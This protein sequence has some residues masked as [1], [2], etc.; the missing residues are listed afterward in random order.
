MSA[1]SQLP[2]SE[3]AFLAVALVGGGLVVGFLAG[4]LGIGGGGIMVPIL[5][6]LFGA[7]GVPE[8]IRMHLSVATSLAVIIPT[9]IR[10][11]RAH[12]KKGAVD[13]Q[14]IRDLGLPVFLGVLLGIVVAGYAGGWLL[15]VFFAVWSL[16]IAAHLYAGGRF[17]L[18]TE[19]PGPAIGRPVGFV[20]GLN[21]T[22]IGI[23]GGAQI[24]A[25]MTLFGR[26]IHQAVATASGFGPIIAIPAVLGYVWSGWHA[27]GQPMGSLGYVNVLGAALIT[28]LSVLAAPYGAR[29]AHGM[30]RRTLEIC[31][32]TFLTITSLRFIW[33][34]I[35]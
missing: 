21:S 14:V 33:T 26:T 29:T 13:H 20:V 25:Y 8:A 34:M 5:Y 6:E 3:I 19:L 23:G 17:K 10:S 30:S 15:K 32:A 16:A 31:F 22:L 7:I 1:V 18:G 12:E 27:T 35:G 9:S 11:F 28:P 4:L 24:T 2:L